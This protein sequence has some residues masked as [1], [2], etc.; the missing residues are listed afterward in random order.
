[1]YV[2]LRTFSG[3]VAN[4]K[5]VTGAQESGLNPQSYLENNDAYTFFSQLQD[6]QYLLNTGLTGTNVMDIQALLVHPAS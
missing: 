2:Y 6:G 4:C 3:A 5:V 1:M